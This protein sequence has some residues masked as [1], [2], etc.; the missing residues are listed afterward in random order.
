MSPAL[1]LAHQ[2][3]SPVVDRVL[4]ALVELTELLIPGRVAG[5]YLSGSYANGCPVPTS[6]LDV[7]VVL[8]SGSSP[9]HVAGLLATYR[10]CGQMT[11][12]ALD[13]VVATEDD[14][15][16][17]GPAWFGADRKFLYGTDVLAVL[18]PAVPADVELRRWMQASMSTLRRLYT[19]DG[20]VP[21]PVGPPDGADEWLGFAVDP[22]RLPDGRE[23]PGLRRL[24]GC[25]YWTANALI[26]R[27][28][29]ERVIWKDRG[30]ADRF[31]EVFGDAW[32][33]FLLDVFTRVKWEWGYRVPTDPSARVHLR[34]LCEQAVEF[35]NLFLAGYREYLLDELRSAD[36]EWPRA[37][38]RDLALFGCRDPEL[39]AAVLAAGQTDP[40][41]LGAAGWPGGWPV[42]TTG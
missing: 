18:T 27:R 36:P 31:R 32:F 6:D 38:A 5:Y 30:M 19:R 3:G 24:V 26:V 13:A 37:A 14:M 8:R 9:K 21:F 35:H 41:V 2:T 12:M 11:P 7:M 1:V 15:R 34:R 39:E 29:G 16:R 28:T 10:H 20:V 4:T 25:V 22:V 40:Q 17:L 23:E 33:P 42:R